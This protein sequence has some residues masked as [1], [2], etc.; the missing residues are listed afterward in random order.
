V[1]DTYHRL[2]PRPDPGLLSIIVP[3]YDEV[4][5]VAH[6]RARLEH[7]CHAL[8]VPVEIILVNDGSTDRTMDLLLD[9][10]A[11]NPQVKVLGLA[12]NFGHQAAITAGLDH[13]RGDAVAIMDADLQDPPEVIADMLAEY[14]RG[15]DVVYGQRMDREGETWLKR[16]SAWAFYRLM[17]I[18][19][20]KD[21]HPDAG[22]FR[23][24][25][26]PCL[27]ALRGMRETHRF[28]RGMVAWVGFSQTGVKYRRPARVGGRTKYR[29]RKMLSFAWTAAMAFSPAPL[30]LSFLTGFGLTLVGVGYGVYAFLRWM[31]GLYVVPG[32]TSVIVILCLIGGAIQM[33]LGILGEY[34]ARIFEESKGR[35]LYV[36]ST[37]INL[38]NGRDAHATGAEAM[39][40]SASLG[41]VAHPAGR[42]DVRASEVASTPRTD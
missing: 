28:L 4:E 16:F 30:R 12:R 22:D 41:G 38:E 17:R 1:G 37:A 11:A 2:Q 21:L 40:D 25:S 39:Q 7:V 13:A 19:I 6:L 18:F 31:L 8:H 10:A 26:R 5:V 42:E 27:E 36:V 29:L 9:W 20:Y 24:I 35:P 32:W 14:R 15:Y 3:C 34:V 33:S 23:L